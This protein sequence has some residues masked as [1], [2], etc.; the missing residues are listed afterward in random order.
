[1]NGFLTS[2]KMKEV[3][4][5]Q[6]KIIVVA[7]LLFC[8]S[9][10]NNNSNNELIEKTINQIGKNNYNAIYL[11][12]VDSII[13][14]ANNNLGYYQ[15]CG[16]SKNC[17][18]DSLL[19][20]NSNNT[21]LI[22]AI[23]KQQLITSSVGDDIDYFYGEKIN[24]YWYFF[25]GPN[26]FVLRKNIENQNTQTPL[27]YLQLHGIALT[28]I[29]SA[30]LTENGE[31]NEAWFDAHFEGPGWGDFE[32]QAS[33]DNFLN[34]KGKRFNKKRKFFEAIHL[35]SVKNNWYGFHKDSIKQL[36]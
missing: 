22:G 32:N 18:L 36:P 15:Y 28:E 7:F 4:L 26:L 3:M 27:T 14:W 11:N 2:K 29:F 12:A 35:Q 5:N 1:M 20:F 24:G 17:F 9:S 34:L 23:L 31:I 10:C 19:C 30:Y 33:A 21:R 25:S 8:S 6:G 16:K 13:S